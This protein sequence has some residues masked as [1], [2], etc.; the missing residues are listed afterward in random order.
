MYYDD[1]WRFHFKTKKW[2]ELKTNTTKPKNRYSASGGISEDDP[3]FILS[4]GANDNEQF[5]NT[6][7]YD[8]ESRNGWEEINTGTNN[9][10]PIY[11]HAR[12][13]QAGKM[14][15]KDKMLLFGGCL[16]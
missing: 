16:R 4:H 8:T 14:V 13:K 12:Y 3:L 7:S 5:S 1:I 9:Y 10:N 6:F 11:P 15:T 2:E